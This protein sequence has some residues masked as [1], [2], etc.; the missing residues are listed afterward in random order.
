MRSPERRAIS[1]AASVPAA[2]R[3]GI[4]RR[5]AV[6]GEEAEEAQDPE[7]VLGD[8]RGRVADETHAAGLEIGAAAEIV[9]EAALAIAAHG[10]DGE[11]APRRIGLEIVG[12][13]DLGVAAVGRRRPG[14]GS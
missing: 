7:I 11:V 3:L 2:E 12:E 13:R 6:V 9:E 10:V 8:P 5:P 4:R 14:A 1:G